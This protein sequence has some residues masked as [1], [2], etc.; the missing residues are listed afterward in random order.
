MMLVQEVTKHS[1]TTAI[2]SIDLSYV[3]ILMLS[4]AEEKNP[5][6]LVKCKKFTYIWIA[7]VKPITTRFS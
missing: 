6:I 7:L 2:L 4:Y 3:A 1:T 5:S